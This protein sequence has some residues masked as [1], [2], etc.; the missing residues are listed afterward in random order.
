M[1]THFF[2]KA[3]IAD[4]TIMSAQAS[5]ELA[6][7]E[8]E[9]AEADLAAADAEAKAARAQADAAQARARLVRLRGGPP[10][11]DS[12]P[13]DASTPTESPMSAAELGLLEQSEIRADS[14]PTESLVAKTTPE[15]EQPATSPTAA[16]DATETSSEDKG[17]ARPEGR[18]RRRAPKVLRAVSRRCASLRHPTK[19]GLAVTAMLLITVAALIVTGLIGLNH[20]R[21]TADAA[22]A[23]AFTVAANQGVEAIT[24]LDFRNAQSDVQRVLDQ[25]TGAFFEDFNGRSEDFASVIEQSEV[26]TKGSV[27]A[28]AIESMSENSAVVL[29]SANSEVTNAAGA[30]Q[31]PRVWRLR[32]T[33]DDIDGAM[34]IS[35]VDFVP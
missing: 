1:R 3:D 7:T 17:S 32:V 24:T 19:R 18:W 15:S 5:T 28:S 12:T 26:T 31:E 29:V 6:S 30:E 25:S 35:K 11:G 23:S 21:A 20:N 2:A 4:G 10:S 27:T 33:V 16:E 22:R 9:L 34:K 14:T 8:L 13:T